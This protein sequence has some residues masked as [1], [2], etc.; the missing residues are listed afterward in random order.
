[1]KYALVYLI[2]I[3]VVAFLFMW[4]LAPELLWLWFLIIV[5]TAGALSAWSSRGNL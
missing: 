2:I 1:M 3:T 5:C 4:H